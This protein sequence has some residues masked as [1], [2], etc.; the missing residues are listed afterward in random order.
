M[1]E[2]AP[3]PP[4]V[5]ATAD[6]ALMARIAQLRAAAREGDRAFDDAM[7]EASEAVSGAG[8]A[9]SESWIAAQIAVSEAEMA[10]TPTS[11][12]IAELT[13]LALEE[14]AEPANPIDQRAIEAASE[15]IRTLAERQTESLETLKAS[16]ND[17]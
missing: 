9:G 13:A 4:P 5:P 11:T 17:L 8:E 15:E 2:P 1:A 3:T 7:T 16:L 6:P 10:R 14:T 12:A